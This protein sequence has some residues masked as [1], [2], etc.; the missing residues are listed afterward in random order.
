M[1]KQ[2]TNKP[3]RIDRK[4]PLGSR[5]QYTPMI[6][7]QDYFP[8]NVEHKPEI[9]MS[10]QP[11]GSVKKAEVLHPLS[12]LM[13]N[14]KLNHCH[15]FSNSLDRHGET[16]GQTLFMFY[17]K[18]KMKAEVRMLPR[19][20]CNISANKRSTGLGFLCTSELKEGT[21]AWFST[22][23]LLSSIKI[24][25]RLHVTTNNCSQQ[26]AGAVRRC[27]WHYQKTVITLGIKPGRRPVRNDTKTKV[28]EVRSALRKCRRG[29]TDLDTAFCWFHPT[30]P[31]L[32]V[33]IPLPRPFSSHTQLHLPLHLT[34]F[35]SLPQQRK[36]RSQNRVYGGTPSR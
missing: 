4:G 26:E 1:R 32:S 27:E 10:W 35:I 28:M 9:P 6:S 24:T 36:L 22:S 17:G 3:E 25:T 13:E 21:Y 5:V 2:Q 8:H 16:K 29:I 34:L 12:I 33:P 30:C 18:G 23:N 7:T 11:C 31:F 19:A 15:Q 20:S 14:G